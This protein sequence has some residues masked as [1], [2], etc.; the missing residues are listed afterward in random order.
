VVAAVLVRLVDLAVA[1][2]VVVPLAV[3]VLVVVLH[4]VVIHV[5]APAR[6]MAWSHAPSGRSVA[7]LL[8][9]AV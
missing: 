5:V 2:L 9:T 1:V 3:A 8:L 6:A 7:L 4:A